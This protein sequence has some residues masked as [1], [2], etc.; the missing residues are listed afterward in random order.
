ML[1]RRGF[2]FRKPET[3]PQDHRSEATSPCSA[4]VHERLRLAMAASLQ[5]KNA[6]PDELAATSR[7]LQEALDR[8]IAA[9]RDPANAFWWDAYDEIGRAH[10]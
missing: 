4:A 9:G 8:W 7:T 5:G 1:T 3:K 6:T 10:V 2:L